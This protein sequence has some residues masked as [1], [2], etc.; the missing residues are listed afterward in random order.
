MSASDEMTK[1]RVVRDLKERHYK[2][3]VSEQVEFC[4]LVDEAFLL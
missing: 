2:S 3:S 1:P 4:L